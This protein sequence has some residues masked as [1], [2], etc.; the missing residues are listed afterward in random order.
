MFSPQDNISLNLHTFVFLQRYFPFLCS[1]CIFS[2]LVRINQITSNTS[3]R[4][5]GC[6]TRTGI[7]PGDKCSQNRHAVISLVPWGFNLVWHLNSDWCCFFEYYTARGL[8]KTTNMFCNYD[9]LQPHHRS[10]EASSWTYRNLSTHLHRSRRESR[11]HC[12]FSGILTQDSHGECH[13]I[14]LSYHLKNVARSVQLIRCKLELFTI[15]CLLNGAASIL[16]KQHDNDFRVLFLL[17]R[18]ESNIWG[19]LK[20]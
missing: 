18:L 1:R 15:S 11:L 7:L 5:T 3:S 19:G 17:V 16:P 13:S 2:T 20:K 14:T 8:L 10:S 6:P 12:Y 4:D 9:H